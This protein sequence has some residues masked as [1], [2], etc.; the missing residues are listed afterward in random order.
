[1]LNVVIMAWMI[2]SITLIMS[3][4]DNQTGLYRDTLQMLYKYSTLH[5]FDDKLTKRL[6]TQ[7]KL[8]FK[9][10]EISDEQ[11]LKFLPTAVRRKILRRLY[12]PSLLSTNLMKGTRQEFVDSFL[13]HCTVEIFS[14]G[15]ELLKLGFVSSD[16]YLLL[17]GTVE[18]A[19]SRENEVLIENE[20]FSSNRFSIL[21][22][23]VEEATETANSPAGM[24]FAVD[25]ERKSGTF[26]NDLCE[27]P[28]LHID[29]LRYFV[30]YSTH[31]LAL[32][33]R[34][35]KAFSLN[36]Q[37]AIPFERGLRVKS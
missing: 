3:K 11:L 4:R 15:E 2:G 1:M 29:N 10:N 14:P 22:S 31:S 7:L 21:H 5:G 34:H 9:N 28:C 19:Q 17:D 16:L 6:K 25:A 33:V 30:P 36:L 13:S 18:V 23:S 32:G 37:R 8:G 27:L 26:L 12:M 24:C 35:T 20:D